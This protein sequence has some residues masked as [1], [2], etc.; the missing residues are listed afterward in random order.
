MAKPNTK[1]AKKVNTKPP[2]KET[3][4]AGL[5]DLQ[6]TDLKKFLGCGG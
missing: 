4:P 3:P 5:K 6:E 2:K 1:K